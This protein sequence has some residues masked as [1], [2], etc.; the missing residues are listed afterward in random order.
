MIQALPSLESE[1]S[2]VQ[3]KAQ[4]IPYKDSLL[5]YLL[6]DSMKPGACVSLI[7]NVRPEIEHILET[8]SSLRF[9]NTASKC[10]V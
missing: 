8:L 4:R 7:I 3:V 9:G 1:V 6:Q 5:T 10:V 2:N